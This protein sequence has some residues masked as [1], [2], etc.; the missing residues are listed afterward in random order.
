MPNNS[1]SNKMS[2]RDVLAVV[3]NKV[4]RRVDDTPQNYVVEPTTDRTALNVDN[5]KLIQLDNSRLAYY[6]DFEEMDGEIV[7]LSSALDVYSDFI[8][9]SPWGDED[10]SFKVE[11]SG[12]DTDKYSDISARLDERLELTERAWYIVR[13]LCKYGDAFFEIVSTV[14]EVV[15]FK[16]L[17]ENEMFLNFVNNRLVDK[18]LPY[19]QVDS[20]SGGVIAAFLPW[21]I[22]H[23]KVGDEDYGINNSVLY[24]AR[25]PYRLLR[26][27]EDTI[28]VTRLS[29]SNQRAVHKIDVTGMSEKEAA[30]Y[31]RKLKLMNKRKLMFDSSGKL[32][33]DINPLGET[34]DIYIPV[35]KGG[36]GDFSIVGGETHLGE[37]R[38]V[39]YFHDKLFAAT[40]VPK[41]FLG[42]ERDVNAKATLEQ[43]HVAFVKM[44]RRFRRSF[45]KGL[46]KLYKVEFLLKGLD[47]SGINIKV[48]FPPLAVDDEVSALSAQALRADIVARMLNLGIKYPVEWVIK[49]VMKELSAEEINEL[50][51]LMKSGGGE[52]GLVGGS[53]GGGGDLASMLAGLAGG[54]AA[55]QEQPPATPAN[56]TPPAP[57]PTAAPAQKPTESNIYSLI[58]SDKELMRDL[59]ELKMIALTKRQGKYTRE[60]Y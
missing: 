43:Q 7:E 30:E 55:P 31:I 41:A 44:V 17:P 47:I 34:E 20:G 49:N 14:D 19:K 40:K 26:M 8:I 3:F 1:N 33:L 46:K 13:N 36:L 45:A 60:Y 5:L 21:E 27:L 9:Y 22:I 18:N 53:G 54:G 10:S 23:F 2:W 24:K 4:G 37:I 12:D 32:K 52:M 50:I 11:I 6:K 56:P 16:H 25:R 59:E 39:E 58:Y 51:S 35:R 38:D 42:F 57:A 28:L 29:R 15:S 48:S